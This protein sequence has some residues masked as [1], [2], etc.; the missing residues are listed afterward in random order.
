MVPP[1]SHGISRAPRYFG[2]CSSTFVFT[3][4][5]LTFF[6]QPSHAVRLTIIVLNAVLN[7]EKI[8][9]LGLASS[10]FARHY[11]QNLGWFL[12]LA[13]LRCFSSGG[14]PHIPMNSVYDA[15]LWHHA[16][17]S[18]RKSAGQSLLT[19][20]RSLSQLTTSF[21]GS[22][23]QGIRPAL[24]F[25]LPFVMVLSSLLKT[26]VY[27]TSNNLHCFC[28]FL[29]VSSVTF[30]LFNFQDAFVPFFFKNRIQKTN[31]FHL[32][33]YVLEACWWAQMDS[34]HRPHAYQACALTTW[35][36]RPF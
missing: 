17:C 23:C 35:A 11:S 15:W 4:R 2:Y 7:P 34:N 20:H 28:R 18:I 16:D 8:A 33:N 25:A 24:L 1:S 13:L 21:I 26:V 32:L 5:I 36:M 31:L 22:Q 29:I 12:F 14:S 9:P 10:A 6:D 3:Y 27:P 30:L 19:A